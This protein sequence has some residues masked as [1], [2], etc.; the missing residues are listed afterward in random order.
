MEPRRTPPPLAHSILETIG[1]TPLVEL[2]RCV[3]RQGLRGRLL[4]KL[5]SVNPGA[6]KKDRIALEIIRQAR[7]DGSLREGQ[8]VVELTSGNT[9]AGL[10][11]VCRAL[12]HP[13]VAVMSRGNTVERARQMAALGAEVFLVDQAP[14]SV[15]GRVSGA[16]LD[17]VD[18]RTTRLAAERG[19][20][21]ADQ[22]V[23]QANILA[24]ERH[25]G[26]ELWEQS[27]GRVDVFVDCPG[28]GGTFTGVTRCLRRHHPG[29]RAYVVEPAGAAVLA[30]HPAENPAHAIQ[31]AGYARVNLPLFDR[32]LVSGYLQVT[33]AQAIAAARLLAAEEGICAGFSTGAHLAAA[34][35]LLS[36]P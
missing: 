21:R 8:A 20:F 4:A 7:A 5:E 6:S 29:L 15:P 27:G 23:R 2:H 31:G 36:C 10:A 14:G 16:D 13:F 11:I 22:F 19:A 30:G 34:A 12:G 25:T 28:T 3:A 17:L 33:D 35:P 32:D 26:P 18:E 1:N 9:G 24:H